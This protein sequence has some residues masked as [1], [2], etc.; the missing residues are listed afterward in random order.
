MSR[1]LGVAAGV[2]AALVVAGVA[3]WY[4]VV[5]D[6][7]EPVG[8]EEAVT[9]FR[10]DTEPGATGRSPIPEGVY[11][12]E[13]MGLEETDA[14]FGEKHGYPARTTITATAVPC[15]VSLLWRPIKGRSTR[16]VL[17]T[18]PDGWELRSQDE[19]H[20]FFGQTEKTTYVCEDTLI[21]P[22]DPATTAW[23]VSCT[24]GAAEET[25]TG[26][27]VG[28]EAIP[29]GGESVE[30]EHVRR[31]TTLSGDTRGTTT[32]DLWFDPE[33]GVPVKLVLVSHTT[34]DSPIGEVNY[35]EDVTLVLTS[36]EPRR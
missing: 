9:S 20:T 26:T 4:F 28:R 25:G 34:N 17:C 2:V 27:L 6:S 18:T 35:D 11:V 21:R 36:L 22:A 7:T 19:R 31:E 5:R 3:T 8:V 32:H 33:T 30:A 24:T 16:L 23:D 12:Y 1:A 15:G 14:L 13:T 10:T 29:V